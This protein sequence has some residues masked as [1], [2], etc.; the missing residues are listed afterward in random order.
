[1]KYVKELEIAFGTVT[2]VTAS[3]SSYFATFPALRLGNY[4]TE[5]LLEHLIPGILIYLI[6]A[7]MVGFGSIFHA[8]GQ[9]RLSLIAVIFGGIL[10]TVFF[11]LSFFG[12][13]VFMG[14]TRALFLSSPAVF[15]IVTLTLAFRAR[16][17]IAY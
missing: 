14:P 9:G 11:G 5:S 13:A 7:C 17:S 10:V 12:F 4:S 3:I 2:L 1:M 16:K 6:P 8:R 15:A